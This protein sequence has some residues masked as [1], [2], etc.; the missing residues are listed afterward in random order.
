M[1]VQ[2]KDVDAEALIRQ[3]TADPPAR[4]AA[5]P[6][7]PALTSQRGELALPAKNAQTVSG[8]GTGGLFTLRQ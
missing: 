8:M 6:L 3:A 1:V 5:A 4:D 2:P 7:S